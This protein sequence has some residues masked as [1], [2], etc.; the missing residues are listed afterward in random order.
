M[1][2]LHRDR[3][4]SMT[5]VSSYN[6]EQFTHCCDFQM[7]KKGSNKEE[8]VYIIIPYYSKKKR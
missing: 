6:S 1:E 7:V 3:I 8:I 5:V 2:S 4:L